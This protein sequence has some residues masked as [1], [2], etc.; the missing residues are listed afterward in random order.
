MCG[1]ADALTDHNCEAIILIFLISIIMFFVHIWLFFNG[2]GGGGS[3]GFRQLGGNPPRPLI[4]SVRQRQI[5]WLGFFL[6]P[7]FHLITWILVNMRWSRSRCRS[8]SS[9]LIVG[10]MRRELHIQHPLSLTIHNDDDEEPP[11]L[12]WSFVT[13]LGFRITKI[14]DIIIEMLSEDED[15]SERISYHIPLD[16][17]F[18]INLNFHNICARFCWNKK[19]ASITDYCWLVMNE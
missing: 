3:F 5:L 8:R 11:S 17:G 9:G 13:I 19:Q 4:F 7:Y 1:L 6:L 18:H 15:T 14:F 12:I 10:R 16:P 2:Q